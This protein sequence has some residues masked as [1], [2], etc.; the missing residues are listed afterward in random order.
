MSA[1]AVSGKDALGGARRC[2]GRDGMEDFDACVQFGVMG[3][4]M[5]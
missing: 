3:R 4:G 5:V 2:S 1:A